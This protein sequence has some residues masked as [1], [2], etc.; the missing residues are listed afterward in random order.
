MSKRNVMKI[1]TI[2]CIIFDS[3]S[4]SNVWNHRKRK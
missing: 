4:E 1:V 2:V 3:V